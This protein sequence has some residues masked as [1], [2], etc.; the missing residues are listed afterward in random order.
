MLNLVE[1]RVGQGAEGG[2]LG[3]MVAGA[4]WGTV[5]G[6]P[7]GTLYG[8]IWGTIAGGMLDVTGIPMA[9]GAAEGYL[10]GKIRNTLSSACSNTNAMPDVW[11][12]K[13]K[14]SPVG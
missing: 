13:Q 11:S 1:K 9:I 4:A 2:V 8:A 7:A 3:P 5:I 6:G 12:A 10:E 14:E